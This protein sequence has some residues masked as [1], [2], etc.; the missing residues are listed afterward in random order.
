MAKSRV[1]Q[2]KKKKTWEIISSVL[3]TVLLLVSL[4]IMLVTM[5]SKRT[6]DDNS[7]V[8][9]FGYKPYIVNSNSMVGMFDAGDIVVVK[10]VDYQELNVGDVIA[11]HSIDPTN[12]YEML[13][14]QICDVTTY[15]GE[16]AYITKGI[17]NDYNDA[18]PA[19]VNNI[20]G[21]YQF[22]IA[23]AGYFFDFLKT[24]AGYVTCILV[25][26]VVLLIVQLVNFLQ[27][28]KEYKK[29]VENERKKHEEQI[30]QAYRSEMDEMR[31]QIEE[32][33]KQLKNKE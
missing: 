29:E 16:T 32:L 8:Y 12:Y 30:E 17:V 23:K 10:K 14:H 26:F 27:L 7:E 19:V 4:L 9:L 13:T 5:I 6:L 3:T 33:Q 24:P 2:K 31:K 20:T 18:Y 21:K 1:A 11:F 28:S 22:K 15:D 25:P